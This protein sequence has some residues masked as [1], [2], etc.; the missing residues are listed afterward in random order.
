MHKSKGGIVNCLAPASW[1]THIPKA[2]P[3]AQQVK[4]E[5]SQL[6]EEKLSSMHKTDRH[7][8]SPDSMCGNNSMKLINNVYTP[9]QFNRVA[10]V[11][12]G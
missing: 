10:L 7:A 11:C 3:Q 12:F 2:R 9:K 8:L 1:Q 5:N 6:P 4:M